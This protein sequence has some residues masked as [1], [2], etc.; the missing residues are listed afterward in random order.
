MTKP[1]LELA[2][3]LVDR[4]TPSDELLHRFGY[5]PGDYG[6][7]CAICEDLMDG[8]DKRASRCRW[9]ATKAHYDNLALNASPALA[10]DLIEAVGLLKASLEFME[11]DLE[12]AISSHQVHAY[13]GG[14]ES[15]Q[16]E[17][18]REEVEALNAHVSAA[19]AF[20]T[21]MGEA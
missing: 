18:V 6:G 3:E 9:C 17:E 12:Q 21:K 14:I 2:R 4:L 19:R 20:I 11:V 7:K 15:I 16:D 5:A 8:V 13:G 1:T 10:S